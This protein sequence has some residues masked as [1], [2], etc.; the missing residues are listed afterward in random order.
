MTASSQPI[1]LGSP[2]A[3]Q[4]AFQ[5]LGLAHPPQAARQW[6]AIADS[7]VPLDLLEVV[8]AALQDSL[9]LVVDPD[10]ALQGFAQF[11]T[12][13]RS[14]LAVGSLIE[15]E[16]ET[17]VKLL[18]LLSV[19]DMA[20]RV[21]VEDPE[22]LDL[23]RLTDGR[24][25]DCGHLVKEIVNDVELISDRAAIRES[26]LRHKNRELLR[27]VYGDIVGMQNVETVAEQ[28]TYLANAICESAF[29][30]ALRLLKLKFGLPRSHNG[31]G[32]SMAAI[33]FG[34]FGGEEQSYSTTLEIAFVYDSDG[35]TNG[36]R[37]ISNAEFAERLACEFETLLGRQ[38]DSGEIVYDIK[39][40]FRS[41]R[42]LQNTRTPISVCGHDELAQHLQTQGRTWHRQAFIKARTVAGDHV[43]GQQF[44]DSL[45]SWVFQRYITWSDIAELQALKRRI[46][47]RSQRSGTDHRDVVAGRGGVLDVEFVI[48]YLQLLNGGDARQARERN[49]LAAI[50]ELAN[51]AAINFDEQRILSEGYSF[52]KRIEHRLQ[53]VF[54]PQSQSLPIE[55]AEFDRFSQHLGYANRKSQQFR[56]DYQQRTLLVR[57]VLDH[58][59][60]DAFR[61]GI[62]TA[63]EVD[64]ILDPDPSAEYIEQTLA[65]YGFEKTSIAYERLM[66]LATERIR[67]LSTRRCRT[68]LAA[69][70]PSLLKVISNTPSPDETLVNLCRVS[71]SL[72]GKGVLWELFS[73][74]PPTL[75]LY[76]RLC[77]CSPYLSDMLTSN[78]GMLDELMD[79]LLQNKLPSMDQLQIR[80]NDLCQG[81]DDVDPILHSFKHGQHLAAGVRDILGKDDIS[82]TMAYLSDVAEV[83]L[84]QI[85]SM[86]FDQLVQKYGNPTNRDG[87]SCGC[88]MIALGKLGGREPNYHSNF[89]IVMVYESDGLTS[90]T[91]ADDGG[92]RSSLRS[93]K[94]EP[95]QNHH[96]FS[97]LTQ[98]ILQQTNRV[99]PQG[100]VFEVAVDKHISG[101][102]GLLAVT[103]DDFASQF[104]DAS[105]ILAWQTLCRARVIYGAETFAQRTTT[106]IEDLLT[107][108]VPR[109]DLAEKIRAERM[110][111]EVNA[112]ES[113][114]KRA[115]GGT[116]D[117]EF[118]VSGL[119]LMNAKSDPSI[120]SPGTLDGL[121]RL[122][123]AGYLTSE[124]ASWLM[125]AY[126]FL[127]GV[128]ARLRLMNTRARHD[129]PS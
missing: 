15:R 110:S 117:I 52:L 122:A 70:S 49:T 55:P 91:S 40:P 115:P 99:G 61:D 109:D 84:R 87:S 83:C 114:L 108:R 90:V 129:L 16:P 47:R 48:Q 2:E 10:Q 74:S 8:W 118:I 79:S 32:V 27:I 17:L 69:I 57:K 120:L 18:H 35:K 20:N 105:D 73:Y 75:D 126:R 102:S 30:S 71:D 33:G 123:G 56:D 50:K 46:E 116:V 121:E 78:P 14:P 68:F 77:A 98:R 112:A 39:S 11:V 41:D 19:G 12:S 54:G 104:S 43:F 106:I 80:L 93:V 6:K 25:V 5:S 65:P 86:Q 34:E 124:E 113:N 44:L 76:V 89:D 62:E 37:S 29:Q 23:L 13:S 28:L 9:P 4:A 88:V 100:R 119:Q 26:L 31:Q 45:Q 24:P 97:E 21:L 72:G 58:L 81:A 82:D 7:S 22:A 63:P 127:R 103:L 96:F 60:H 64:L 92:P 95:T 101:G 3:I 67:F 85:A 94:Q 107:N 42:P 36:E 59:L 66:D 111:L 38:P 128:E 53:V 125:D 51:I 1:D